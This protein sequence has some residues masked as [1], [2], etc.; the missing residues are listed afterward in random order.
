MIIRSDWQ[1]IPQIKFSD[2][3]VLTICTLLLGDSSRGDGPWE[4]NFELAEGSARAGD[5]EQT[6]P[7][8]KP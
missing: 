6:L 4:V 7:V 8:D 1:K 3:A 2:K 5:T